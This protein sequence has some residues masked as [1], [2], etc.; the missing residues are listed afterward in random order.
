MKKALSLFLAVL[1]IFSVFS[2]SSFAD[3]AE[4]TALTVKVK[5]GD[6]DISAAKVYPDS[7]LVLTFSEAVAAADNTA[8]INVYDAGNTK[9]RFTV[10]SDEAD[11]KVVKVTLQNVSTGNYSLALAANLTAVSGAKL[12]EAQNFS[13]TVKSKISSSSGT[14]VDVSEIINTLKAAGHMTADDCVLSFDIN[15][16]TYKEW[17]VVFD[18]EKS[19]FVSKSP[20]Q[21]TNYNPYLRFP[22]SEQGGDLAPNKSVNLPTVTPPKGWQ[23][24]G[25]RCDQLKETYASGFN[26]FTIPEG[27]EGKVISLR[28]T[29]IAAEPEEDTFA[30]V[31]DILAKIFGTI[32][33]LIA[34]SGDTEAG[35]AFVRKVFGGIAS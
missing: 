23:F 25:W 15:G 30:K 33:G 21:M 11:A 12:N 24:N 29:Y 19:Q 4:P 3:G 8:N 14:D 2:I 35:I 10:V 7:V 27:F 1:M 13:F 34:Y 17:Q 5:V 26:A 32:I 31:F 20:E 18:T 28:A 22:A 6:A 16:G 9:A